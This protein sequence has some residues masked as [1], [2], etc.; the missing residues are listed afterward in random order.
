MVMVKMMVIMVLV[1]S[2]NKKDLRSVALH[3]DEREP[4]STN[5]GSDTFLGLLIL[6]FC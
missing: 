6:I 3:L 5:V 1:T 2:I 4:K